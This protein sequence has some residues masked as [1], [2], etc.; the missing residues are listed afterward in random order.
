M[1]WKQFF[2]D[3]VKSLAWP[4]VVVLVVLLL[5]GQLDRVIGNAEKVVYGNFEISFAKKVSQI[6]NEINQLVSAVQYDPGKADRLY[7]SA[8]LTPSIA[9]MGAWQEVKIAVIRLMLKRRPDLKLD[10]DTPYKHLETLLIE[11]NTL[12]K[13]QIKIFHDLRVLRNKVKH[14]PQY[15]VTPDQAQEYIALALSL[16]DFLSTK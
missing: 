9:I 3:I 7:R 5:R 1:N 6:R 8:S 4:F 2:A 15:K 11:Y 12:D 14:V 16:A 10:S 13:K